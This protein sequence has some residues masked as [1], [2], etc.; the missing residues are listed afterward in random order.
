MNHCTQ[1]LQQKNNHHASPVQV[2]IPDNFDINVNFQPD[3]PAKLD[4]T[5]SDVQALTED[6]LPVCLQQWIYDIA[7]RMNCPPDYIAVTAIVMLGSLIGTGCGIKPKQKDEW[8]V[9]PNLWG[10][11]VG[12]PSQLK[13]PAMQEGLKPLGRLE[14]EAQEI[15]RAQRKVYDQKA[16]ATKAQMDAVKTAM[17]KKA[18]NGESLAAEMEEMAQI[19]QDEEPKEKRYKTNDVT[20]EKLT[21]LL[22]ENPRGLLVFRDELIGLLA[23]WDKQGRESDR[24]FYL[25]AWNGTGHHTCDRIGRGTTHVEHCCI[26]LL[27]AIQPT[28]IQ[29]YLKDAAGYENDGFVQRLQLLVYPDAPKSC[30]VDEY[31]N[32]D[33]RNKVYAVVEAIAKMNFEVMGAVKGQ[34]DKIP[35]FR[36]CVDAH[37]LFFNW[38]TNLV[39]KIQREDET[40]LMAEHLA[41]YRSL[42]PSLALIFHVIE[43]AEKQVELTADASPVEQLRLAN[44]MISAE[45]ATKAIKW[46]TYLETH[47]RRIYGM[48]KTDN[49][50]AALEIVKKIKS[51]KLN[52]EFTAKNI[53]HKGWQHLSKPEVV[54]DALDILEDAKWIYLSKPELPTGGRPSAPCYVINPMVFSSNV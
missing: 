38:L 13:S 44:P 37:F 41:K 48:L 25:E 6:M 20:I 24:A 31:P 33:A 43:I 50:F 26:S 34:Y 5:L 17:T 51:G 23:S 15:Y 16:A 4:V 52:G 12:N 2:S 3:L 28:K 39:D 30:I 53:Y 10:G 40:P 9:V 29:A 45:N 1:D 7:K 21:E 35:A 22:K 11:I 32:T 42:M 8:L 27:G 46:C 18:K 49:Q 19:N 14:V 54:K 47:A 36:F